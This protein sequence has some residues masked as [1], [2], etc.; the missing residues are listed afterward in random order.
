MIG[1]LAAVYS[2]QDLLRGTRAL[3]VVDNIG[4][5]GGLIG[6]A[7]GADDL[8]AIASVF[9]LL[10]V[11]IGL[12]TWL[13]Y[14]ESEANIGD[15]PSRKMDQWIHTPL[16]K[17]LDAEQVKALLPDLRLLSDAPFA[18]LRHLPY[19]RAA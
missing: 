5:L 2:C 19:A 6:G 18:S 7:S 11:A 14:V 15:G 16:C 12:R 13:E 9:Q 17:K 10:T 8:S 1:A 4:G 3:Q